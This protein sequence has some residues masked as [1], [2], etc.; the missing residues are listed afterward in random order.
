[1]DDCRIVDSL[2]WKDQSLRAG[3]YY[4]C[5]RFFCFYKIQVCLLIHHDL[6]A[7]LLASY[8]V[9]SDHVGDVAFSRRVRSQAHVAAQFIRT[10][11]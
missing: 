1:M 7:C 6:N 8:D 9:A 10:L 5:I 2:D 3:G 4:D 11:I